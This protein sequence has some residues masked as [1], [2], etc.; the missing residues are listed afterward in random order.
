MHR[1][2]IVL[3]DLAGMSRGMPSKQFVTELHARALP[4]T[5]PLRCSA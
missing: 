4:A 2:N 3:S 5:R 1:D